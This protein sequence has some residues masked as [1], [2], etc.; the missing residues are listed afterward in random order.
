M[1]LWDFGG[2]I[3]DISRIAGNTR[4]DVS[5][6]SPPPIGDVKLGTGNIAMNVTAPDGVFASEKSSTFRKNSRDIYFMG[7]LVRIFRTSDSAAE[8]ARSCE[9]RAR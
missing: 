7:C 6:P 2:L 8:F 3:E 9:K 5:L 4:P 1:G